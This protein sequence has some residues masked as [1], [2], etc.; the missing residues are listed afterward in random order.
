MEAGDGTLKG[1]WKMWSPHAGAPKRFACLREA[2]SAKAGRAR[3]A[4]PH[5]SWG[6]RN[7]F[8]QGLKDSRFLRRRVKGKA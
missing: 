7:A 5:A 4:P 8:I 1:P 3:G 2:A 6:T